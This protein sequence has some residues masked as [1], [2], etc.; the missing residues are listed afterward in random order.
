MAKLAR[1]VDPSKTAKTTGPTLSSS[2]G[3]RKEKNR[4]ETRRENKYRFLSVISED[5]IPRHR[6]HEHNKRERVQWE[7]LQGPGCR[8]RIIVARFMYI[9]NE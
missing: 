3:T 7:N 1:M 6:Y 8:A 4:K 5:G 9:H 2:T